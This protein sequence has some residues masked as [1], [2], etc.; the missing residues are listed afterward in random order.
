MIAPFTY[1]IL[2]ASVEARGI[3]MVYAYAIAVVRLTSYTF[4]P[5]EMNCMMK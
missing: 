5:S 4:V 3:K 1:E 2:R